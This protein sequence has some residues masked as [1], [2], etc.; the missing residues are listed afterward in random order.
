VRDREIEKEGKQKR[1][2]QGRYISVG[3]RDREIEKEGKRKSE[4]RG[5]RKGR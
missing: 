4:R 2:R 3:V 5:N 1:E